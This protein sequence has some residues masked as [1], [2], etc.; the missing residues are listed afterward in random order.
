MA[1]FTLARVWKTAGG[2]GEALALL[3]AARQ[4]FEEIATARDNKAAEGMASACLTEQGDCL[5]LLGRL[6]EAAAA[7]QEA[8]GRHEQRGAKRGVAVGKGQLGS[9]RLDQGR[10]REALAAYE[11]TR[12]RFTRLRE[13]GSVATVW[14][15]TGKAYEK[16]GQGEAAEAAYRRALAIFVRLGNDAGQATTLGQLGNLY[17]SVLNRPEEAVGFYRQAADKYIGIGDVAGEGRQRNNLAESLRRLRRLDAARRE[18]RRAMECDKGLGHAAEPWKSWDVLADI[19]TDAGNRDG[20]R[21]AKTQA[22]DAYL[23]Y[24]RDGGEN[25]SGAGRLALAV[26]QGLAK[27]QTAE[28]AALLQEQL[29]RFEA[30]GFGGFIRALQAIVAGGREPSLADDPELSYSMAAEILLLV[31]EE[32]LKGEV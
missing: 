27:G 30:A 4:G 18:I 29:P 31:E 1:H 16:M 23:A 5:W 10:H 13:D 26:A 15:Q 2:A 17:A 21:Q 3:E 9:V 20:A 14:H 7:Y 19:E 24:R 11:E 22:R 32:S 25:H 28:A 12:S 8:I 6:E